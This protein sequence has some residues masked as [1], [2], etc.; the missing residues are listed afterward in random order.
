[1]SLFKVDLS[2]V[3]TSNTI[4]AGTY[5]IRC[6]D[7]KLED[8]GESQFILATMEVTDGEHSGRKI[9]ERFTT[10]HHNPKAVQVGL[11]K[12]K[13]FLQAS[14]YKN[15]NELEL[16]DMGGLSCQAVVKIE[17]SEGYSPRNTISSYKKAAHATPTGAA[18]P[19]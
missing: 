19:F 13:R 16:M 4:P 1:M 2:K 9:F 18:S 14:N 8:K 10:K 5:S 6:T 7:V 3:E 12:L 15:P 17:E 11:G